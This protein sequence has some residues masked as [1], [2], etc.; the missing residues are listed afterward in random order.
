MSAVESAA[1]STVPSMV[2]EGAGTVDAR[3]IPWRESLVFAAGLAQ[4]EAKQRLFIVVRV[5]AGVISDDDERPMLGVSRRG[6]HHRDLVTSPGGDLE[7]IQVKHV[8]AP[9]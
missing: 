8:L 2:R 5:G 6:P 4:V 9:L 7:I 1:A 3:A